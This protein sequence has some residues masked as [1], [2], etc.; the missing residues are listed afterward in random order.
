VLAIK[1]YISAENKLHVKMNAIW[2]SQGRAGLLRL[3]SP[4]HFNIRPDDGLIFSLEDVAV[5]TVF[6]NNEITLH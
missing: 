3:Y 6:I 5:K 1:L 2:T 4:A